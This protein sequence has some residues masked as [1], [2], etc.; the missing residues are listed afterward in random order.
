MKLIFKIILLA[1]T[2]GHIPISTLADKKKLT[3]ELYRCAK[4]VLSS[5]FQLTMPK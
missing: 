4:V 3:L 2:I 5:G 1:T